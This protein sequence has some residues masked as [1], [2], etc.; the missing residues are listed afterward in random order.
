MGVPWQISRVIYFMHHNFLP[1]VIDHIN[2]NKHDNRIENLRAATMRENQYNH[3]IQAKNTSGIKGVSWSKKYQK[4][5]ACMRVNG[6]NKNLGLYDSI[7]TAKE[8][9]ELA[10]EMIHGSF[11][12]HGTFKENIF[13]Q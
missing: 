9:L 10:R 5:Y 12:N 3:R 2:G 1:E 7:E 11:A 6:K 8:F 13:C 4:W